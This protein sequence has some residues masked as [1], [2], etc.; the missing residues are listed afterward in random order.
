MEKFI[1]CSQ[2][3]KIYLDENNLRAANGEKI[4]RGICSLKNLE[5]LSLKNN[6]LGQALKSEQAPICV[7]ANL[8]ITST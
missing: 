1:F 5:I 3:E 2:L 8:L 7:L 4:L 6:F